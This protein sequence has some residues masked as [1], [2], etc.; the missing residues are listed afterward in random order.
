MYGNQ[1]EVRE[2]SIQDVA[3]EI[4]S[5]ILEVARLTDTWY[6]HSALAIYFG[7]EKRQSQETG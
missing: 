7:G 3:L 6:E 4:E 1:L 5:K 2:F